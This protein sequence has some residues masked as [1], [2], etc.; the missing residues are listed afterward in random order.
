MSE[1]V[2]VPPTNPGLLALLSSVL[3]LS[4][5]FTQAQTSLRPHGSATRLHVAGESFLVLGVETTNRLL[6]DPSDLPHLDENLAMYKAACV[7]TVLIPVTWKTFEP[8]EYFKLS[9]LDVSYPALANLTPLI[10][11]KQGR[12]PRELVAFLVGRDDRPEETYEHSLQGWKLPARSLVGVPTAEQDLEMV[13]PFACLFWL[14]EGQLL[15]VGTKMALTH[16]R[17]GE[18]AEVSEASYGAHVNDHWAMEGP[19]TLST[20]GR[21]VELRPTSENLKIEQVRLKLDAP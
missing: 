6:D 2:V 7:N 13:T 21:S 4:A 17:E 14:D 3:S 8:A 19:A 10:F 11:E 12:S 16:S 9:R 20:L 5:L 18:E 15:V 1:M